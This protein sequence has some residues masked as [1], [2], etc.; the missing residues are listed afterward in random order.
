M[1]HEPPEYRRTSLPSTGSTTRAASPDR[2]QR[3]RSGSRIGHMMYMCLCV[4]HVLM[5]HV[6]EVNSFVGILASEKWR[7]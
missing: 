5:W 1:S 4:T 6:N 2:F 3:A 7:T